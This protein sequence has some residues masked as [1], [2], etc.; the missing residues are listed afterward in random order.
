MLA[1]A[2]T[3]CGGEKG[4]REAAPAIP[5]DVAEQLAAQSLDVAEA[6]ESG[7]PC[8]AAELADSLR[9]STRQ[10]IQRGQVPAPLESELQQAVARLTRQIECVPAGEEPAPGDDADPG[11]EDDGDGATTTSPTP[12]TTT[13]GTTTTDTTTT[14]EDTTTMLEETTTLDEG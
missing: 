5:R 4:G 1:F 7:D 11:Q 3:S 14:V 2:I 13:T 6:L 10:A 9:A 12:D 8:G